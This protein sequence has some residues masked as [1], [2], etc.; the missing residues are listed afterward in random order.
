MSSRKFAKGKFTPKNPAKYV[1]TKIPYYRSSWEWNFMNMCD[2]NPGVQ[3]WASE[4]ITIPYRDP[5]TNRNTIYLPDFFIQYVD[6]HNKLHHEVIEIKPA[7]QHI[8][9]RVGKNKYNQAQFIKNQ[10]KWAAAT[11][12]CKQN[13]LT[14]RVINEDDIFHNGSK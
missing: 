5:L 13:G 11:A 6:K 4:A 1:G 2:T 12:Y 7:S 3:K 9:E 14:F 8:L 10:A